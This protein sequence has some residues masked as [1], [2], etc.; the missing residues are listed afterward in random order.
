MLQKF[1]HRNLFEPS[2]F[3]VCMTTHLINCLLGYKG[4]QPSQPILESS[5]H[6]TWEVLSKGTVDGEAQI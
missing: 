1:S 2:L 6:D 5:I 3:Y 4:I